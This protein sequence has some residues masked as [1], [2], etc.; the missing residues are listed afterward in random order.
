MEET[1]AEVKQEIVTVTG[2]KGFGGKI[3]Y[4]DEPVYIPKDSSGSTELI[5]RLFEELEII[6]QQLREIE[7]KYKVQL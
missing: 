6:K 3:I 1:I 4:L 2:I 7:A 5:F